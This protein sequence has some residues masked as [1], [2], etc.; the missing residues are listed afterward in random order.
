[1]VLDVFV[2]RKYF[3]LRGRVVGFEEAEVEVVLFD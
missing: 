1:M 3:C 2:E